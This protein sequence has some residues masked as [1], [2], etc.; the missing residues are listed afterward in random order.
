[1]GGVPQS[2]DTAGT[3]VDVTTQF[4]NVTVNTRIGYGR[5]SLVS[6][7]SREEQGDIKTVWRAQ[8]VL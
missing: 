1:V 6:L 3:G 7:L 2:Q 5:A 4:F 8:G